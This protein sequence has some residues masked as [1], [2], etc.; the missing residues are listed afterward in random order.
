MNLE[1][2]DAIFWAVLILFRLYECCGRIKNAV[3]NYANNFF[4]MHNKRG[5]QVTKERVLRCDYSVLLRKNR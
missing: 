1:Q 3:D 2:R 5:E 4:G